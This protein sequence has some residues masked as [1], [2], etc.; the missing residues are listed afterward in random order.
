MWVLLYFVLFCLLHH[1]L[2]KR[3]SFLFLI[4]WKK[5]N[6]KQYAAKQNICEGLWLIAI[7]YKVMM[8]VDLVFF[9]F[10][11][12]MQATVH[13]HICSQF[14]LKKKPTR[15]SLLFC[16]SF[17]CIRCT[18]NKRAYSSSIDEYSCKYPIITV[19]HTRTCAH[20]ENEEVGSASIRMDAF[21]SFT[22]DQQSLDCIFA[23][24]CVCVYRGGQRWWM[25]WQVFSLSSK[26][27]YSSSIQWK[28]NIFA[29]S[30]KFWIF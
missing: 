22:P 5:F 14:V 15:L 19:I 30:G 29:F 21:S 7:C 11:F 13:V 20:K 23:S 17:C 9:S 24:V 27:V 18:K 25:Q 10:T 12:C 6:A 8:T 26:N 28:D 3:R 2:G 4:G 16:F 1:L